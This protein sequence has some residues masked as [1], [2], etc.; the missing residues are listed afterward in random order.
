LFFLR[1][2]LFG[3]NPRFLK[4]AAKR[5][6]SLQHDLAR[7]KKGSQNREKA[8]QKLAKEHWKV[9][10][11]RHNHMHQTSARM[12]KQAAFLASEDA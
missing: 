12:I 1:G 10:N 5:L 8:R 11:Q 2:F 9:A 4:K 3:E 7:K 6:K